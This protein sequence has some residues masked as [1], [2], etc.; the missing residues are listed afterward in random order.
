LDNLVLQSR[1]REWALSAIRFGNVN[2]PRRQCPI[3]SSLNSLVQILDITF[4]VGLVVL[5]RQ[6]IH[7]GGCVLRKLVERLLQQ[8]GIDVVE[9]RGE[10]L[11][12]PFSRD[13]PYAF[14]RL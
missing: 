4:E 9:E 10:L 2:A 8:L 7:A 12:L 14:Q 11:L 5:P 13:F 3:C 6:P 1:D